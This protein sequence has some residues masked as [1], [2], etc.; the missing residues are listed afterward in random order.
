M[1]PGGLGSAEKDGDTFSRTLIMSSYLDDCARSIAKSN[2]N[3]RRQE[4]DVNNILSFDLEDWNQLA[5]RL[6]T[7]HLREP[8]TAL[9]RQLDFL[10]QVLADHTT[11]ATFF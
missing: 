4:A 9:F 2:W 7:G 8:S 5:Y 1:N 10:L 3:C 6:V 11:K